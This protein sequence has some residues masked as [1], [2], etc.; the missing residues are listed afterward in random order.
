MRGD[1]NLPAFFII[2]FKSNFHFMFYDN[3]EELWKLMREIISYDSALEIY[4]KEGNI[5]KYA[6]IPFHFVNVILNEGMG[7]EKNDIDY[8]NELISNTESDIE[9]NFIVYR[10][11]YE[12]GKSELNDDKKITVNCK[13]TKEQIKNLREYYIDVFLSTFSAMK[14]EILYA[15]LK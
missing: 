3:K 7:L 4:Y 10:G 13:V 5:D 14:K 6:G 8:A 12:S 9:I 11:R 15:L 2:L 1:V